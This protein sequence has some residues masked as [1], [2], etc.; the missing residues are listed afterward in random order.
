MR[1]VLANQ[2]AVRELMNPLKSCELL[3]T[4]IAKHTL[5]YA[6]IIKQTRET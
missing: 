3:L 5:V 2:M 4:A 1:A 6:Q